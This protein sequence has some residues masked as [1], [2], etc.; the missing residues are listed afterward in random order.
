MITII[1]VK[2]DLQLPPD[3]C[4]VE[5]MIDFTFSLNRKLHF[6]EFYYF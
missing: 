4:Q 6:S 1:M 3:Y 5:K 2:L